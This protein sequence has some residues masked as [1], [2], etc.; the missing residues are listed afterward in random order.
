MTIDNAIRGNLFAPDF[1]TEPES[2]GE[3]PEWDDLDAAALD[4]VER[5]LR[6]TEKMGLETIRAECPRFGEWVFRLE[7]LSD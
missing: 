3:L 7:S 5:R 1:L 4:N 6:A 2:I